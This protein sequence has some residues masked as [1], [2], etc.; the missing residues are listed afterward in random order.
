ME[1]N[2][3]QK[4][5][6]IIIGHGFVMPQFK[7]KIN[8]KYQVPF[9]D[10]EQ[11]SSPSTRIISRAIRGLSCHS[12]VESDYSLLVDLSEKFRH[13]EIDEQE[14]EEGFS[15][16][17][18][19]LDSEL[20]IFS[21][22]S[23]KRE[24]A[25]YPRYAGDSSNV[26]EN[27]NIYDKYIVFKGD[28]KA[29]DETVLGL[30]DIRTK[31]NLLPELKKYR[32]FEH[33]QSKYGREP[34]LS[35]ITAQVKSIFSIKLSTIC[36]FLREKFREPINILDLTCNSIQ[37]DIYFDNKIKSLDD[38][39]DNHTPK[40]SE[41]RHFAEVQLDA[42]TTLFNGRQWRGQT[43]IDPPQILDSEEDSEQ[44][45]EEDLTVDP[46]ELL[47]SLRSEKQLDSPEP[48][49]S[50]DVSDE[51]SSPMKKSKI[52]PSGGKRYKY[53]KQNTKKYKKNTKKNTKNI[54]KRQKNIK[55]QKNIK[56]TKKIK[57][58]K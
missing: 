44:D 18:N 22:F 24:D 23:F 17:I 5:Y 42:Y 1:E 32:L 10:L 52:G 3:L 38:F 36:S 40:Y 16:F 9:G 25:F 54:K 51:K 41:F 26:Q 50:L 19:I 30:Y 4:R 11:F 15:L 55:I 28:G 47:L 45:S 8:N 35:E 31:E 46:V 43:L 6:F 2:P 53:K 12:S 29:V 57:T 7:P 48:L 39:Y 14:E 27:D 13:S 37:T 58:Y 20:K 56:K 34:E 21:N 49:H 33:Y